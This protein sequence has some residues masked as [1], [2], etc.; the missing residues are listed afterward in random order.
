MLL[1]ITRTA[2]KKAANKLME[3]EAQQRA[4]A[5]LIDGAVVDDSDRVAICI[6][7]SVNGFPTQLEAFM[8]T[9][10][11]S[12]TYMIQTKVIEDPLCNPLEQAKITMSPRLGQGFFSF[13]AHVFLFEAK[14]MDVNDKKLERKFIVSYDNRDAALRIIKYPGIAD[15]LLSLESDCK[16]KEMVI[17]TDGGLYMTQGV[18]FRSLDLDLCQ[19]TLNYMGQIAQVLSQLF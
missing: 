1:Q 14:G 18:N 13:F 19:A 2:Q 12:V 15:I 4:V 17:K 10:P 8:A 6:K 11:F 7:G 3:F 16:L 9:W 5:N